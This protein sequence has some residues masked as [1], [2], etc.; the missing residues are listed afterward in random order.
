MTMSTTPTGV[1]ALDR[2]G[3]DTQMSH[4]GIEITGNSENQPLCALRPT[5]TLA[6]N[7]QAQA[8]CGT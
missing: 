5:L 1:A 3:R 2:R 7:I 8:G 4:P 6:A